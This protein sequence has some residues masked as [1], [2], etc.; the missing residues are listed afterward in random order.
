M[1]FGDLLRRGLAAGAAGGLAAAIMLWLVVEPVLE[2]ALKVEDARAALEAGHSHSHGEE[3]PLVSRALQVIGGMGTALVVG[4]LLGI[5][6]AVVF[7]RSRHR[8]PAATDYGR[9]MVLAGLGFLVLT[10]APAL[11]IPANPPAV[12]DPESVNRRTLLYVL[13]IL[14][15]LALVLAVFALDQALAARGL[16]SPVRTTIDVASFAIAAGLI[17]A[18]TPG[19][20]DSIPSDMP[21][22]LIWDF[23]LASLA[24]LGVLWATLGA[25]F[26][27]L[28]SPRVNA[29]REAEPVAA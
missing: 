29:A 7:A 22:A 5:V 26:G 15:A 27:L 17:F 4:C 13:A 6:F 25:V 16:S 20:P 23:R 18:L 12:G 24:Q 11:K 21:A 14:V 8:L 19:T 3:E 28:V 2:K 1:G 10:L 9:A